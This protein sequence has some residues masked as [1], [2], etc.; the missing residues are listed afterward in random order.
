MIDICRDFLKAHN[1]D[2]INENELNTSQMWKTT[3]A[4]LLILFFSH[5]F[6]LEILDFNMYFEMFIWDTMR[7]I[8]KLKKLGISNYYFLL[9]VFI[10]NADSSH[11][12][13]TMYIVVEYLRFIQKTNETLKTQ[14]K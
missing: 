5:E 6:L 11:I 9:H 7:A 14:Q 2:F 4:Q 3:V 13:M 1:R 10:D 8:K 12:A